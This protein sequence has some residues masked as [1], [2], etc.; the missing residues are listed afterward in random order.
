[1]QHQETRGER[2]RELDVLRSA[3]G[4]KAIISQRVDSGLITFAIVREF[5]DGKTSFIPEAM[6]DEYADMVENVRN[7]IRAIRLEGLAPRA[8]TSR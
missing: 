7:R 8:R 1:M 4:L 3:T 5:P 6:I 2:F